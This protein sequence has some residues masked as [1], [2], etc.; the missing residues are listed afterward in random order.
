MPVTT[1]MTD[2]TASQRRMTLFLVICIAK[3]SQNPYHI[4]RRKSSATAA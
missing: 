4:A 3:S 2:M 1:V